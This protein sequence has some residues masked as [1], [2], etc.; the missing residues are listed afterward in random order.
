MP[1]AVSLSSFGRAITAPQK[2]FSHN[3][4]AFYSFHTRGSSENGRAVPAAIF[5]KS[6]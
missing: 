5:K 4:P 3:R 6:S 1:F 2:H